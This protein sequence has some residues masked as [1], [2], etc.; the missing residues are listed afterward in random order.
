MSELDKTMAENPVENSEVKTEATATVEEPATAAPTVETAA[1]TT[2]EQN[3]S[4]DSNFAEAFE[5]TLVRI[6]NGQILTGSVVQIVDGEVCV[7]IGY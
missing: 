4:T 1:E 3:G 6:R 5:K 7:N 2:T